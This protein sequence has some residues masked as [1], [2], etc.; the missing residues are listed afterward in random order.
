MSDLK[1][2]EIEI[3]IQTPQ[4][5]QLNTFLSE[6]AVFTGEKKQKD[7]YFDPPHKTFLMDTNRGL[8]AIEFIRIRY[9]DKGDSITYKHWHEP[10]DMPNYADEYESNLSDGAQVEKI[11]D[12]TGYK[13]TAVINKIRRTYQYGD[14]LIELDSIEGLG[15]FVEVEYNGT[16]A[17]NPKEAFKLIEDLLVEIG[18][19]DYSHIETG[20]VQL[21]WRK[22]A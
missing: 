11:F 8:D 9:S 17:K 2:V 10:E 19:Q 14:F 5:N 22:N 12:A 1:N 15:E 3:T 6:K 20:Y 18:I 21:W 4:M 13:Q 7:V 16:T